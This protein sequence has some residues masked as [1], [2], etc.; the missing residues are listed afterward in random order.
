MVADRALAGTR[1]RGS[2]SLFR[3]LLV[4][5][6]FTVPLLALFLLRVDLGETRR[7]L[8]GGRYELLLLAM[9]AFGASL[10]LQAIRWWILTR[11][12]IALPFATVFPILMIGQMGNSLLPLRGG[13]LLRVMLLGRLAP[14]SVSRMAILGTIVI[15]RL[16]DGIVLVLMLLAFLALRPGAA[17]LR[18]LAIGS[19]VVFGLAGVAVSAVLLFHAQSL[20]LISRLIERAPG[21]WQPLLRRLSEAFLVGLRTIRQP[22]VFAGVI[23]STLAFWLA[24]GAVYW[25]VGRA[26]YLTG[27]VYP[28]LLTTAAGNL[29]LALPSSQGGLGPFEFAVQRSLLLTGVAVEAATAYAIGLHIILLVPMIGGGL[30]CAWVVNMPVTELLSL[31]RS[32][33]DAGALET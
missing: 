28:Y 5:L 27:D 19:G 17:W 10:S 15:E 6:V 29:S 32:R 23:A 20:G 11:T 8:A 16:L 26:F 22:S 9:V 31:R 12:L 7:V 33:Q 25:L 3:R 1:P 21:R 14:P 18:D 30:V 13:D 24:V 2:A 4:G